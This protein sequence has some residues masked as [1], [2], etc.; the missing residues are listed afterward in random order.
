MPRYVLTQCEGTVGYPPLYAGDRILTS[1]QRKDAMHKH[2][3]I[4]IRHSVASTSTTS[5]SKGKMVYSLS[6][7]NKTQQDP[8]SSPNVST[9]P[10]RGPLSS[11]L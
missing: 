11:S 3:G 6:V 4:L 1:N 7:Q 5:C 10:C 2:A 9:E 8:I